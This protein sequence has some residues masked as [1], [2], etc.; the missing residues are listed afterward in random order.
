MMLVILRIFSRFLE[1]A[2][3]LYGRKERMYSLEIKSMYPDAPEF[4]DI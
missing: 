1:I 4:Q 3:L 2:T